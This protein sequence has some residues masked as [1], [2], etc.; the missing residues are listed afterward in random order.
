MNCRWDKLTS[1]CTDGAPATTGCNFGFCAKSEQFAGR[2]QLKYP[3]I[4]Y[5]ESLYGKSL[6]MKNVMSLVVKCVNDIQ[7]AALKR[8][9]FRQ[10]LYWVDKQNRELLLHTEAGVY[11]GGGALGH[12]IAPTFGWKKRTKFA[13]RPFFCSSPNFGRKIGLILG[14]TISDSDLCFSQIFRSSCPPF[15]NPAY[16]TVQKWV[17]FCGGKYK[18]DSSPSRTRV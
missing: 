17:G 16:A 8:R 13:W 10:L 1:V 7:T 3:C 15:Q 12:A 2:T 4:I 6:Q 11:L 9:E 18:P 14:G 5:Q